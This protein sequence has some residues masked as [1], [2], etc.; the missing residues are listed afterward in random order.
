MNK[1]L[2]YWRQTLSAL[3]YK[4]NWA[5]VFRSRERRM[6]KRKKALSNRRLHFEV[7]ESRQMLA[8]ITDFL[9]D[10]VNGALTVNGTAGEDLIALS[11]STSNEVL[12]GQDADLQATGI[13]ASDV[14]SILLNGLGGNDEIDARGVNLN[15]FTEL[16]SV[17]ILGGSGE[18]TI[19]GSG[20]ADEIFGGSGGLGDVN[21]DG[22]VNFLDIP[23]FIDLL[24]SGTYQFEG[25]LNTDGHVSFLDISPFVLQISGNSDVGDTIYGGNGQ[26]TIDGGDGDDIIHGGAGGDTIY[27]GDGEDQIDG[28]AGSVY[29]AVSD[30]LRER[31]EALIPSEGVPLDVDVRTGTGIEP[32]LNPDVWTDSFDWT[33]VNWASQPAG[34]AITRH[35]IIGAAHSRPSDIAGGTVRFVN[36]D[37]DVHETTVTEHYGRALVPAGH[38]NYHQN[39]LQTPLDIAL[40][41]HDVWV[42]LL[43][44][45]L[46]EGGGYKTYQ[47]PDPSIDH[48]DLEGGLAIYTNRSYDAHAG[49][50]AASGSQHLAINEESNLWGDINNGDSGSPIFVIGDNDEEVLVSTFSTGGG[51]VGS[52]PYLGDADIQALIAEAMQCLGGGEC[53]RGEAGLGQGLGSLVSFETN[54]LALVDSNEAAGDDMIYGGDDNDTVEGGA[55][56]DTI[57]GGNG[58]D[59]LDGG[60]DKDTI[61]GNAGVDTVDGGSGDDII[62]GGDGNDILNG[63]ADEDTIYGDAGVDEV[64]GEAG[65][66]MLHGG[67]GG[68]LLDGGLGR[69]MIYGDAGVDEIHGGSGEDE[70][71]GGDGNDMI[72]GGAEGDTIYGDAGVDEIHG[73]SGEDGIYGGDGGDIIDGGADDD[74][75]YGDAG[76]D[77]IFGGDGDDTLIGGMGNDS[78]SGDAGGDT[79]RFGSF[80]TVENL[81]VDTVLESSGMGVDTLDFSMFS[82]A[83]VID[84]NSQSTQTIGTSGLLELTYAGQ[85]IENVTG[86]LFTDV[87]VGNHLDNNLNGGSG[88]DFIY[89]LA[90]NDTLVGRGGVDRIFGGLGDDFL[91]GD[92][93]VDD[94]F[95][96]ILIDFEGTNTIVQ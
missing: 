66:D 50:I 60:V 32:R 29:D 28:D 68:D 85:E 75:L 64:Y 34:T 40:G 94:D 4:V 33:G 36:A 53:L 80:L 89:G 47:L 76:D 71:H 45:P 78:L 24:S 26:D 44:D 7:L 48:S 5:A 61:F 20:N 54:L 96:D 56:D 67:V 77:D 84:L 74:L 25:D 8:T 35:I 70:I 62:H 12:I 43:N 92:N 1:P 31:V 88:D 27:G 86:T 93:F 58:N 2:N 57:H 52:G 91:I 41:D 42:G 3:G 81:G 90:G 21:L 49:V 65:D 13:P 83:V 11:V 37:G 87:I 59:T 14:N 22:T 19:Y 38:G 15:E 95:I 10:P 18:D 30:P 69:D 82:S 6:L 23:S 73:D 79:Y 55:G 17:R 16:A 39:A 9:F 46:P 72:Y 51:P 63:G